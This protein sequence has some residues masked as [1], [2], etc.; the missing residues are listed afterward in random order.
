VTEPF[1]ALLSYHYYRDTDLD[2]LAEALTIDGTAPDIFF[3]S[4]AYSAE[5]QGVE[6]LLG[7]YIAWVRRWHHLV[8]AYSNLDV[9]RDPSATDANQQA[10]EAAGLSPVPVFHT[11][12]PWAEFERL[13]E[14]Y[15][16]VALGGMVGLGGARALKAWQAKAHMVARERGAV[17]HGFGVSSLDALMTFPWYSVDSSSWTIAF[18]YGVVHVFDERRGAMRALRLGP[19][20]Q[21][22]D[23]GP[24]VRSYG[25][26]PEDFIDRERNT[27]DHNRALAYAS[28]R[29]LEAF[30]RERHGQVTMPE[31]RPP[32][33]R[34]CGA[35]SR[36]YLCGWPGDE[37]NTGALEPLLAA[38]LRLYT[39]TGQE[40]GH[41]RGAARMMSSHE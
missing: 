23:F 27:F 7:D 16:Y 19:G 2:V 36:F 11:L 26:D 38:G 1:R 20:R 30:L 35:G 40:R 32:E 37:R 13:C 33:V 6:V 31:D 39:T 18:K 15:R 24:L 5:S 28:H 14:R 12:S 34:Q 22:G 9:I 25:M 21:W 3:D 41:L 10:M 4:G 8:T 17:L 29:R